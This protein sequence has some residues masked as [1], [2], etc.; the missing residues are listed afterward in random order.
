M[1]PPLISEVMPG[2]PRSIGGRG[3]CE[4]S[5]RSGELRGVAGKRRTSWGGSRAY[6]VVVGVRA[7]V[8]VERPALADRLDEVEVEVADDELRLVRVALV[9]DVVALGVDE[10]GLAVEV[11]VAEVLDTDPV[12]GAHVVLVGHGGGRLLDRP[13]V[14]AQAT[15]GGAGV[16]DDLGTVETERAPALGEVA[17]VAD[18]DADLAD[19]GVEDGVPAVARPEVELLPEAAD[20][21]DVLLAVL[22][23]VAP[24]GVAHRG[25]VVEERLLVLVELRGRQL[26]EVRGIEQLLEADDLRPVGGGR[27]RIGRDLVD[28][29]VLVPGPG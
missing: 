5:E 26:A 4:V 3:P 10:V 23:E 6:Q 19:G 24:V 15:A 18:V 1:V 9:A 27:A 13:E 12:D 25:G 17:V 20:V 16:E 28:H 7:P 14:L 11:V 21:G 29:R 22:A 2:P 8:A